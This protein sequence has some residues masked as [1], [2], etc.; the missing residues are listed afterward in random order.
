MII[1]IEGPDGAG[2]TTLA[3][4]LAKLLKF[5]IVHMSYPKTEE[6]KQ[7]MF[8]QYLA[9]IATSDG[10]NIILDRC[11]YSEMVYGPVKRDKSYISLAQMSDLEHCVVNNGGGFIIYCSGNAKT[12]YE[13]SKERGEDYITSLSELTNIVNLYDKMFKMPHYL[14]I[15]NYVI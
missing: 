2:K 3:K 1:L 6:E 7:N 4:K 9:L 8:Q 13:R 10:Q 11:W 15:I 14:P 5:Q 12:L